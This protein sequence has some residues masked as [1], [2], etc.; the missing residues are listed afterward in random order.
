MPRPK[1]AK[2][3]KT[4]EREERERLRIENAK[5]FSEQEKIAAATGTVVAKVPIRKLGKE[6]LDD[7]TQL[8]MGMAAFF[9]KWPAERGKNPN[10][11]EAKFKEYA[12]LAMQA[13]GTLAPY[14]SPRLSAVAIGAAVVNKIEIDGGMPDDFAPPVPKGEVVEFK[15]GAIITAEETDETARPPSGAVA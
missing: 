8:F 4:I 11:D 10:E 7:L 5:L 12:M 9:Q 2:N 15:P 13:A 3:K 14:Q 6:V 1:G